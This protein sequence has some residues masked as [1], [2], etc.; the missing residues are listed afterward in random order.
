MG[1]DVN[2]RQFLQNQKQ[3]ERSEKRDERYL[4][5]A[6]LSISHEVDAKREI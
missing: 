1:G 3:D 4:K 6:V 2:Q 5:Y